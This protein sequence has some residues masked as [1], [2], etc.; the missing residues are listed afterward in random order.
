MLEVRIEYELRFHINSILFFLSFTISKQFSV[1]FK[2]TVLN[3]GHN[4]K[5]TCL[6]CHS[7]EGGKALV[8][9]ASIP[10]TGNQIQ[11]SSFCPQGCFR[12]SCL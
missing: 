6:I 9:A 2:F 7:V 4:Q 8:I 11:V 5:P 12:L 3:F 10:I 1:Y